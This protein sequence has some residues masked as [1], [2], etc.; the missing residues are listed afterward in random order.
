MNPTGRWSLRLPALAAVFM[1]S[2]DATVVVAAFPALRGHFAAATP[3]DLSWVLNGYTI[4]YA[5]LLVPAGRLADRHGA[6]RVF[7]LGLALFTL[8]SAGCALAGNVFALSAARVVQAVGAAL[9]APA[10]LALLLA[11]FPGGRRQGAV[12]LWS[13]VGAGAAALG[14]SFGSALIQWASWPMIFL[15][16]VPL[17]IAALCMTRRAD[18]QPAA[19]DGAGTGA[20]APSGAGFDAM[21]TLLLIVGVGA[22]AGGLVRA[23]EVGWAAPVTVGTLGAGAAGLAI[24]ARW[25]RS[26]KT[27]TAD[28]GVFGDPGR[29]RASVATLVFGAAFGAGFLSF[30]LFMTGVWG[31]AQGTAGLAAT[32]GPVVV[33]ALALGSAGLTARFGLRR[34]LVAGGLL[35]AASNLWFFLRLGTAAD[36]FGAWLPGQLA[37]G[38]AIGLLLPSLTGAALA[39]LKPARYAEGNAVNSTLRQLGGALG[40]AVVLALA[41]KPGA[42]V[43]DFR[44]VYA[45]LALAGLVIAALATVELPGAATRRAV[46]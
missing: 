41:G 12:G 19:Q 10:S 2:L 43:A 44:A 9:L 3:A 36:Y 42:G 7:L 39:G 31:F 38:V 14:P 26:R 13:A 28:D 27:P 40:V 4:V 15:L 22:L 21:G 16:N 37:G 5:A 33:I 45:L 32:P 11:T 6:R 25:E 29:L 20:S 17:G 24:L 1:V 8:A 30:Y 46:R 23:G 35:F 34:L 18:P